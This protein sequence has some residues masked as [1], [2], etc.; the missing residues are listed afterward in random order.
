MS[1]ALFLS[2]AALKNKIISH[3]LNRTL[4]ETLQNPILS[5][6]KKKKKFYFSLILTSVP[7][8]AFSPSAGNSVTTLEN[9]VDNI[10][11]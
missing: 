8:P 9:E 7:L 3:R 4:R 1:V 6:S 10:L 2:C 5:L 11:S